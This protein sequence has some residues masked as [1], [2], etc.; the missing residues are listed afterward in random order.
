MNSAQE[1][2]LIESC[3]KG[4]SKAQRALY[5][6]FS[7]K[8]Y[9]LCLRYAKDQDQATE[10]LQ[11]GFIKVFEKLGQ[12][13]FQ[14]PLGA[15]IRRIILN[16][17]IN[18][19]KA[20]NKFNNVTIDS[21]ECEFVLVTEENVDQK[22]DSTQIECAIN[23]LREDYRT[24]FNLHCIEELSHKEISELLEIKETTSRSWLRRAREELRE[25]LQEIF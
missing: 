9:A 3:I 4:K 1:K 21:S 8:M 7:P 20:E 10:M 22:L 18:I 17:A 11:T 14:G 25:K 12:Y 15:W 16:N 2:K 24:V 5:D 19:I 6:Q 13:K 23:N